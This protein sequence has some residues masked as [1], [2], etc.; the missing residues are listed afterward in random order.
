MN[1]NIRTFSSK[2]LVLGLVTT[3]IG[4]STIALVSEN[5]HASTSTVKS[6]TVTKTT[7]LTTKPTTTVKT[8]KPA[9]VKATTTKAAVFLWIRF[10]SANIL[11]LQKFLSIGNVLF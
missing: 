10:M 7:T 2:K 6:Q 9:V 1:T 11:I 3:A 4:I 8:V 5:A